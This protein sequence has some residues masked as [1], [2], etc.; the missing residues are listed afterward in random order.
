LTQIIAA[1]LS[2]FFQPKFKE[3]SMPIRELLVASTVTLAAIFAAHPFDF[4]NAVRKV[5]ISTLKDALRMDDVSVSTLIHE[6]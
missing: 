3:I 4:S 2:C 5:E 1:D 6:D